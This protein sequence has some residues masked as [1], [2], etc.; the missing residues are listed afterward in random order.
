MKYESSRIFIQ[1]SA[2]TNAFSLITGIIGNPDL[3][4]LVNNYLKLVILAKNGG[5]SPFWSPDRVDG[6]LDSPPFVP[7]FVPIFPK[8]CALE[9]SDFFVLK[10]EKNE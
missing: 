7:S 2:C 3:G 5:F 10:N 6:P 9:F 8:I 4:V 1:F